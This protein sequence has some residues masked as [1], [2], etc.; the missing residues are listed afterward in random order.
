[1]SGIL[2]LRPPTGATKITR[3]TRSGD[4]NAKHVAGQ[5]TDAAA[6]RH[7]LG[8]IASSEHALG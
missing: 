6:R 5:Q 3:P 1:M 4:A 8:R 7:A 2:G